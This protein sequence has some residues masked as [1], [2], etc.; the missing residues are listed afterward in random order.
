[1]NAPWKPGTIGARDPFSCFVGDEATADVVRIVAGEMG[2]S[3]DKVFGGG[4]S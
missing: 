2:W 3:P 1:M 4:D